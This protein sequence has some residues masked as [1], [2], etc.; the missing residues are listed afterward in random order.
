MSSIKERVQNLE[1]AIENADVENE[2]F[3]ID[4]IEFIVEVQI[5]SSNS[6]EQLKQSENVDEDRTNNAI[7]FEQRNN[8]YVQRKTVIVAFEQLTAVESNNQIF[9]SSEQTL[10]IDDQIND[11]KLFDFDDKE[12]NHILIYD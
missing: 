11:K 5:N 10:I 6:E 4:E 9:V 3:E 2:E 1:K 12:K 7:V 8:F